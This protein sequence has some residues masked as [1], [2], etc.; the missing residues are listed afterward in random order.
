MKGVKYSEFK[1]QNRNTT[2]YSL[3]AFV[4]MV[5]AQDKDSFCEFYKQAAHDNNGGS[6]WRLMELMK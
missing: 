5:L 6:C 2:Y 3:K 1:S 4:L